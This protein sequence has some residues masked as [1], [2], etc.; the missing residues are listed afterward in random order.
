MLDDKLR[1]YKDQLLRPFVG[2]MGHISP[3]TITVMAMVVGL[4]AAGLAAGQMYLWALFLWL[5]SRILDGMDGLVARLRNQQS[6]FGGYL[7]MVTDSVVYAAVPIGLF[8]G[9]PTLE[10]GISL[11]FLL[12]SFYVNLASWMYL[13][14]ILEKRNLGANTRGELT[15]VTMP[16]GLVGGAE[17]I[18]FYCAFFIWPGALLWL[19][20][21]MAAL[22]VLGTLQRV[23]W[24][25]KN[26]PG[27]L[28]RQVA[29]T[30]KETA[31]HGPFGHAWDE[32]TAA[33][34]DV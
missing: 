24:A 28:A 20:L 29:E 8:L 4:A 5:V 3:N 10:L 27:P 17:T 2:L 33:V 6:D 7:D 22:V 31:V 21:A 25:N 9:N 1:A 11:A 26:L 13:S 30:R 19:F 23:W 16:A 32:H 14:A 18:L 15:T 12:G 34:V